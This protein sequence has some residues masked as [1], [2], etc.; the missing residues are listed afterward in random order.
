[1]ETR[2][3]KD[4]YERCLSIGCRRVMMRME[5]F[6]LENET[7][8]VAKKNL[9]DAHEDYRKDKHYQPSDMI[10]V[11]FFTLDHC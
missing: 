6:H 7:K 1:M 11:Q 9:S 8:R 2:N 5:S 3:E 10:T 4:T